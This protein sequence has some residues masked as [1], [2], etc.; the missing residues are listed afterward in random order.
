M[1]IVL[2]IFFISDSQCLNKNIGSAVLFFCTYVS[3][4]LD[5]I[6]KR[7]IMLFPRYILYSSVFVNI[8]SCNSTMDSISQVYDTNILTVYESSNISIKTQN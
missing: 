7:S 4:L 6:Y 8:T 3:I 5:A 2:T 1:Y